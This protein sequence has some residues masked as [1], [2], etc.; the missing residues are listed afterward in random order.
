[1]GGPA[2]RPGGCCAA[3]SRNGWSSRNSG[4][5]YSA[6]P[7]QECGTVAKAPYISVCARR[8]RP[9]ARPARPPAKETGRKVMAIVHGFELI[10]ETALPEA[11]STARRYRHVKTGADLLSL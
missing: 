3:A 11:G 9:E 4:P 6:M 8:A 2:P 10:S 5:S 1:M 7:R